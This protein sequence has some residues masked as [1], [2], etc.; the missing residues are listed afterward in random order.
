MNTTEDNDGLTE[1]GRDALEQ[2]RKETDKEAQSASFIHIGYTD[3]HSI[4]GMVVTVRGVTPQQIM[5][6]VYY[7]TRA[8]N[9]LADAVEF[10]QLQAQEKQRLVVAT[11]IEAVAREITERRRN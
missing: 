8:A 1:L 4:E 11:D 3:D 6:A 2:D 5:M 9:R 7:L 10:Q